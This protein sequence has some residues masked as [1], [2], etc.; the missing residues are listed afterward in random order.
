MTG[1]HGVPKT[2][3]LI[4]GLI[5][6]GYALGS[7]TH[8]AG[9]FL[10]LFHIE[11]YGEGYPAWRHAAFTVVDASIAWIAAR[12]PDRLFLPLLAFFI[13]QSAT[14]GLQAWREWTSMGQIPWMTGAML[15]LFLAAT[16]AAGVR[17]RQLRLTSH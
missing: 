7:L 8:A 2:W 1:A 12:H 16:I 4:S 3:R 10:L 14:H 17:M 13:E 6:V 15:A 11:M 9:L 5:A